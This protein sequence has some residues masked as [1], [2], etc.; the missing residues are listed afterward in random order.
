VRSYQHSAPGHVAFSM[1]FCLQLGDRFIGF[2]IIQMHVESKIF[3]MTIWNHR[4]N[5]SETFYK[6]S[7]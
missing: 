3:E 4:I 6:P 2:A 5:E 7:S 1:R